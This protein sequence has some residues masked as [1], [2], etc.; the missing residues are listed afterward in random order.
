MEIFCMYS[1]INV[2]INMLLWVIFILQTSYF[3]ICKCVFSFMKE[4]FIGM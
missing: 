3:V 1:F 4:V 2:I